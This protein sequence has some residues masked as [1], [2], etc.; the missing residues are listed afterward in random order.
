V[1]SRSRLK[2][3]GSFIFFSELRMVGDS[4]VVVDNVKAPNVLAL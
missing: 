2:K 1:G 4:V 3:A